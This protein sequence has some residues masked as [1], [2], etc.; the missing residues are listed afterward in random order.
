M[1][2]LFIMML[3]VIIGL[4]FNLKKALKANGILQMVLTG[5]LIFCMGVSLGNRKDFFRQLAALGWKSTVYM[6]IAVIFSVLMVFI[7]TKLFLEQKENEK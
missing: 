6:L 2:I 5:A 3:G 1:V 4:K 7:L